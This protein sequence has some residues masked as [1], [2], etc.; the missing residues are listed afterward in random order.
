MLLTGMDAGEPSSEKSETR[1]GGT[2]PPG[3]KR[4]ENARS[5]VLR[6][7]HF[8][9]LSLLGVSLNCGCCPERAAGRLPGVGYGVRG[10]AAPLH[11]LHPRT[12][13]FAG[14]RKLSLG[15]TVPRPPR[16]ARGVG[17]N[18]PGPAGRAMS[19][20]AAALRPPCGRP[21]SPSRP[22]HAASAAGAKGEISR[23]GKS[24]SA[25]PESGGLFC[26]LRGAG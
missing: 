21:G 15:W 19:A 12:P 13:L 14:A 18:L 10:A 7:P 1:G 2:A 24:G 16:A 26:V 23:K 20:P 11:P 4:A 3:P 5:V 22:R 17:A 8:F 9:T 6:P 25:L